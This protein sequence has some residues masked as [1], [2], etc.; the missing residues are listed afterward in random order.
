MITN[1]KMLYTT[2]RL[3]KKNNAYPEHVPELANYGLDEPIPLTLILQ[4]CGLY[5]ALRTLHATTTP[6][7]ARRFMGL[8]A[9]DYAERILSAFEV[10]AK[11]IKWISDKNLPRHAIETARQFLRGETTQDVLVTAVRD[12]S[13][14]AYGIDLDSECE[15]DDSPIYTALDAVQAAADAAWIAL[16]AR[17][18][19]GGILCVVDDT[20]ESEREWQIQHFAELLEKV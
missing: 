16:E 10:Y 17:E 7:E 4:V 20:P 6:D 19:P 5:D 3:L 12:A 9:C 18:Y 15:P 11:H 8:L 2:I 14:L 13:L 1:Q